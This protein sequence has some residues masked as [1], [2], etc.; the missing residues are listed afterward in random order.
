MDS[1]NILGGKVM[2]KVISKKVLALF[3]S[4]AIVMSMIMS[5]PMA[6]SAVGTTYY[7]DSISGNDSN[8]GQSEGSAW[9]SLTKVN[10]VT[11]APG[12]RILLKA[13][14]VW[15]GQLMPKGSGTAGNPII[16]DKYGQGNLPLINGN[17][18]S[19]PAWKSG[20]VMLVNQ[21]YWE[22][23]NLEVTNYSTTVT[24]DRSGILVFNGGGGTK[25]HIYI[26]NCYVHDVNS[27]KD[28]NKI[29]G[30]IIF[31]SNTWNINKV[32]TGIQSGY[33]DVL[34]EGNHV[35][36]VSI[37]GIR[38]K[39]E[40]GTSTTYPKINNNVVIRN[41][42]VEDI[43]GDGIVLSETASG[44]LVEYN[45][46]KN[47]CNTNVGNRN[48]AGLWVFT[49]NN[50]VLQFNDVSGG[51]Y[52]YNDGEAFDID[53][54]CDGTIYQYNY[55]HNNKG[56]FCLFMDGST[57]SVFRYN[58]SVNDGGGSGQEIFHY[59]PSSANY[60]PAIYNNTIYIGAGTT[61]QIFDSTTTSKYFKF[62]NN[63]IRS[64]GT[65][66]KFC[67]TASTNGK[68]SNNLIYPATIDDVNGPSSHPG[69]I[70]ADPKFVNPGVESANAYMLQST[71]PCINAGAPIANNGGRDYFGNPLNNSPID[72]GAHEY[73][74]TQPDPSYIVNPIA[75]SYVRNGTYATTNYGTADVMMV[76]ADATSYARKA[77]MTFNYNTYTGTNANSAKIKLF[78]SNVNTEP[79]RTLKIYGV[80]DENWSETGI[81]WNNAPTGS[82]LIGTLTVSN[83][84]NTWYEFDVTSYVNSNMSDKKVSFLVV[85]EAANSSTNDVSFNTKE[86]IINPPMLVIK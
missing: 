76:K 55:S 66:S 28:G 48:Y 38:N 74:V 32:D 63:I 36:N 42:L 16:I 43:L 17:G 77:Y 52:G 59:L 25:S 70:T 84:V 61:T 21:E 64:E 26:K 7:V 54:T 19:S 73:V 12:D 23:N 37:E 65:V 80:T 4:F 75:D 3:L 13:G 22:I 11:F 5:M 46:V 33:A 27:N 6:V 79:T 81:N 57:N 29:N 14:S 39:T 49:S 71:S 51:I 50:A 35:K 30:G 69:L 44:G 60:A 67:N 47:F 85:N 82:T 41:N 9:Q 45:T 68:F 83:V 62:Y 40:V 20:T 8:N 58:I 34:V 10:S 15:N 78:V 53:L 1:K 2:L 24:S 31:Y 72:I 86:A 56:G 18:T